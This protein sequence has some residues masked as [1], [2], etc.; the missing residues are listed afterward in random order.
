MDPE[1]SI[2]ETYKTK[3]DKVFVWKALRQGGH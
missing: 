2:E 3:N 1:A